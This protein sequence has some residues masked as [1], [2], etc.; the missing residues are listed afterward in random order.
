MS[1]EFTVVKGHPKC[2]TNNFLA[3]KKN[4]VTMKVKTIEY[5]KGKNRKF[6][7]VNVEEFDPVTNTYSDLGQLWADSV[8]GTLYDPKT[9]KCQSSDQISLIVGKSNVQN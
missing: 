3:L 5:A 9:G 7:L 4:A 6:K 2:L 1:H 8:T